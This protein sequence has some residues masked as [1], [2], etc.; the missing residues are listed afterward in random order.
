MIDLIYDVRLHAAPST[1]IGINTGCEHVLAV[2]SVGLSFTKHLNFH[3]Y[4]LEEI[5]F[6]GLPMFSIGSTTVYEVKTKGG[7]TNKCGIYI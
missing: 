3:F 5:T 4:T 7:S 6:G 1:N 2:Y